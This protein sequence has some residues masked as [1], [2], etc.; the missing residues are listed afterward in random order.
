M[1]RLPESLVSPKNRSRIFRK[2]RIN[3]EEMRTYDESLKVYWDNY[4]VIKTAKGFKSRTY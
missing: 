1:R 3:P 4:S 2:P